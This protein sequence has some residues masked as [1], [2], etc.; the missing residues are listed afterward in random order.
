MRQAVI[1]FAK[2]PAW[3]QA[4]AIAAGA[5]VVP[6]LPGLLAE[7]AP[8][9]TLRELARVALGAGCAVLALYL[10]PPA[11]DPAK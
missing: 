5:A 9:I 4:T 8:T 2:L 3:A 11:K 1:M 7:P 10:R 6:L